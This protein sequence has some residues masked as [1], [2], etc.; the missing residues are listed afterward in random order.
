MQKN[1]LI[2]GLGNIG[3]SYEKTRHNIGFEV[4]KTIAKK[5]DFSFKEK[6][7]LKG[8]IAKGKI[9]DVEYIFLM[10][11]TFM[12]ESGESVRL[13]KDY[14]KID[15]KNILIVVDDI[16]IPFGEYRLKKEGSSGGH[17]GLK[18]IEKHLHSKN[19]A[20]LRIGIGDRKVGHLV[21]H[22]LGKFSKDE[23][24]NLLPIIEKAL[25]FIEKWQTVGVEKIM[26][27]ANIIKK[28]NKK[29]NQKKERKE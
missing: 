16:S 11:T 12:N 6:K 18:S 14:F 4:V 23:K 8:C 15:L 19:Y 22:V 26:T 27:Q 3:K 29:L 2:V 24:A 7:G 25:Y 13:C 9:G 21:T 20:R 10:P 5:N 17:N 28:I 1:I